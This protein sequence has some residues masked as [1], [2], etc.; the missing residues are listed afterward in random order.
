[1][2]ACPASFF[3]KDSR[4]AGMTVNVVL[5]MNSLV[6]PEGRW[7]V[8]EFIDSL[9][10]EGQAKYIFIT[11][12]LQEYGI[13]AKEPYVKQITGHKKLYE[14][15]IKDK[16]GISRILYFA[17]T[18]KKFVLLHGFIKKTDKTPAK[19]IGIAEQRMKDYLSREV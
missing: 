12:L 14:L 18:G 2:L 1:M 16:S 11:R 15:R 13:H 10:G 9:S 6:T 3:K 4:Q 17:H 19:E 5:L 7:P 8:K